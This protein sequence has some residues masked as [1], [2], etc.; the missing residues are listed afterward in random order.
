MRNTFVCIATVLTLAGCTSTQPPGPT[1]PTP[2]APTSAAPPAAAKV[3][4]VDAAACKKDFDAANGRTGFAEVA[5][6]KVPQPTQEMVE[7]GQ[8]LF[9]QNCATCHGDGG[10]GDGPAG[11][12]LDPPPRNLSKP[13][14]YKYGKLE[15]A[16]FRTVKYGVDGSGM[17][18]WN[19]RLKD[20]EMWNIAFF[21]RDLQK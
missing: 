16:L 2:T 13:A 6:L 1:Q 14:E 19:G 12:V 8:K 3:I 15:L 5:A 10:A 20:E 7:A 21:V 4:P 18:P 9:T 11:R 17:A